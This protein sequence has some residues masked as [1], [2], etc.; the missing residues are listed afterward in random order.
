MLRELH[1]IMKFKQ[2]RNSSLLLY[3]SR[4][5][6]NDMTI[7]FTLLIS[8]EEFNCNLRAEKLYSEQ[9]SSAL[10][11]NIYIFLFVSHGNGSVCGF[12]CLCAPSKSESVNI[13]A[14]WTTYL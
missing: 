8:V 6:P 10:Y 9:C 5:L 3:I 4:T 13:T 1:G 11:L 2:I 7:Y 12:Y 14:D